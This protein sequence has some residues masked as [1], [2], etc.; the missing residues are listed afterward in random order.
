[1]ALTE[2][3]IK[4][5]EEKILKRK[6]ELEEEIKELEIEIEKADENFEEADEVEEYNNLLSLKETLAK[7]LVKNKKALEKIK[8][9]TYGVCENCHQAID[10]QTLNIAPESELCHNC[11][12]KTR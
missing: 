9:N 12:I 6:E 3:Q 8:L 2:N 10:F 11:K 5:L 4:I 7:E 1:M